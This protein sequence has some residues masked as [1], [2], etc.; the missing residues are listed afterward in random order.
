MVQI[1]KKVLAYTVYITIATKTLQF[2]IDQIEIVQSVKKPEPSDT[3][4]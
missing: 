4:P 1:L 3:N 2:L